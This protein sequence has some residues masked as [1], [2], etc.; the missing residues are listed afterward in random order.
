MF[1]L[2][3]SVIKLCLLTIV[4]IIAINWVNW[5][6]RTVNEHYLDALRF[7]HLYPT[8][9]QVQPQAQRSH[10]TSTSSPS[11]SSTATQLLKDFSEGYKILEQRR[12]AIKNGKPVDR[13]SP[14]EKESLKQLLDQ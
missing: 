3:G 12:D 1:S 13:L 10:G 8:S 2:I 5:D 4:I 14:S 6:G 7:L 9:A 11:V